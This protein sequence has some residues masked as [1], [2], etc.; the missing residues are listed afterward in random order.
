MNNSFKPQAKARTVFHF[1][2]R[3][4]HLCRVVLTPDAFFL[5]RR[6]DGPEKATRLAERQTPIAA[7]PGFDDVIVIGK[8]AT[9]THLG[10]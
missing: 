6:D 1:D 9:I 4:G 10:L 2:K 5:I 8:G 7:M 3:D